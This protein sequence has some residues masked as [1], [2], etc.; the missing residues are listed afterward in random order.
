MPASSIVAPAAAARP[1]LLFDLPCQRQI[2]CHSKDVI[3]AAI[4][5]SRCSG[6]ARKRVISRFDGDHTN[7]MLEQVMTS[8]TSSVPLPL[9]AGCVPQ[10]LPLNKLFLTDSLQSKKTCVTEGN[11]QLLSRTPRRGLIH[12]CPTPGKRQA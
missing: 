4:L 7:I 12:G 8:F 3:L 11:L 1:V 2:N 5:I 10:L 6:S 9:L